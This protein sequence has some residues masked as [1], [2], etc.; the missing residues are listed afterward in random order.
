MELVEKSF[1]QTFAKSVFPSTLQ[2]SQC[3]LLSQN[4]MKI[5]ELLAKE[6]S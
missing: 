6:Y 4:L 2:N 1:L 3:E 5:L